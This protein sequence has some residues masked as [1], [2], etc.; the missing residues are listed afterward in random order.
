M[1][2]RQFSFEDKQT[3]KLNNREK[4]VP[5]LKHQRGKKTSTYRETEKGAKIRDRQAEAKADGV[6]E[7]GM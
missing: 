1:R 4:V 3:I 2:G 5:S 6:K 7:M